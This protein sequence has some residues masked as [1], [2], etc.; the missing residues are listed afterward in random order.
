[1][2]TTSNLAILT[3][4]QDRV[5]P[6]LDSI[7][8]TSY[9]RARPYFHSLV[10]RRLGDFFKGRKLGAS[11]DVVVWTGQS[12]EAL[13]EAS[14]FAIG[15]DSSA[16]SLRGARRRDIIDQMEENAAGPE[17][18]KSAIRPNRVTENEAT[19]CALVSAQSPSLGR[20]AW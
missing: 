19:Y 6:L 18:R 1:M 2:L 20:P 4:K 7:K 10:F 9:D 17:T 13:T 16:I 15:I 5:N 3:A 11:L 12:T 14:E 8:P